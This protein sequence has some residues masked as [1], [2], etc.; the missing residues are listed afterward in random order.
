MLVAVVFNVTRS[1]A[2]DLHPSPTTTR[3]R[4]HQGNHIHSHTTRSIPHQGDHLHRANT[5]RSRPQQGDHIHNYTNG[6]SRPHQ[7]ESTPAD[8]MDPSSHKKQSDGVKWA[9]V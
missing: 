8:I 5:T 7:E 6:R 1:R 9:N 4:L 2:E 3:S